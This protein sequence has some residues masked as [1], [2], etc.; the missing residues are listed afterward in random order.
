MSATFPCDRGHV[1]ILRMGLL[2]PADALRPARGSGVAPRK[3]Q[4]QATTAEM[5]LP[6]MS[7]SR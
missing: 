3:H 4:H 1:L 2:D 7:V 5:T 6:L